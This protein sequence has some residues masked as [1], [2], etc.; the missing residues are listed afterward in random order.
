MAA[1]EASF[2]S[3][4]TMPN[5]HCQ[6]KIP[7]F[8]LFKIICDKRSKS[9]RASGQDFPIPVISVM[10]NKGLTR[11]PLMDQAGRWSLFRV[12]STFLPLPA[13][14]SRGGGQKSWRKKQ[15]VA[16]ARW[17]G[18]HGIKGSSLS[19]GQSSRVL[20]IT[21]VGWPHGIKGSPVLV[22]DKKPPELWL[23]HRLNW[24]ENDI[25]D[26]LPLKYVSFDQDHDPFPIK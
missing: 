9:I 26:I 16:V 13:W 5:W 11:A 21:T 18:R 3:T 8:S 7:P 25:T 22:P 10:L 24:L 6:C 2:K 12:N 19:C 15:S 1:I 20:Y 17:R 23:K 14:S 4:K